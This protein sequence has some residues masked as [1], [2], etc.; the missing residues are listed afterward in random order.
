MSHHEDQNIG[1]TPGDKFG[2]FVRRKDVRET[3]LWALFYTV[4][5]VLVGTYLY[6]K[7]MPRIM[8]TDMKAIE[9]LMVIFTIIS[10]PVCGF[11]LSIATYT[12]RNRHKGNTPPPDGPAIRT[13]RLGVSVFSAVAGVLCL[14]AVIYGITEMNSGAI[15]AERD[16][17][18]ALVVEVTGQQWVWSFNYPSLGIQSNVLN[19]PVDKPVKFIVKSVDVNHSFWPVQLGVKADANDV[20]P[21]TI[22]TTPTKLGH[23]DVK[24]AELCGLYHA[25]METNG[26]V[27]T[28]ADFNNWVTQNGGQPL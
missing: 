21:V 25:Y 18:N 4:V 22:N 5:F 12:F 16:A 10:A 14:T 24:C 19:L 23:I 7:W 17:T 28:K 26:D 27:M 2:K 1:M 20:V 11:V 3:L 9:R 13:N 15:A 6:P 8:S